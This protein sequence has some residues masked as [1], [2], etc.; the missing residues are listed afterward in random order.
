MVIVSLLYHTPPPPGKSPPLTPP[1]AGGY[2]FPKE[3]KVNTM[4]DIIAVGELLIDFTPES[5]P[6]AEQVLLSQNPGGAPGNV[7]AAAAK[8]GAN[9]ALISRVG[10][11]A[12]G[13]FLV[14]QVA[15]CGVCPDY[16]TREPSCHTTLAF[17]HLDRKGERSFSFLRSPGADVLLSRSHIPTQAIAATPIFHFGGVSL[18]HDPAR[19]ATL[20]A[21]NIAHNAG[22]LVSFDPNWRPSLWSDHDEAPLLL[23]RVLPDVDVIKVS[24]EELPLMTGTAD[25][26]E[27][28]R[29]LSQAGVTLVLVSR[30]ELGAYYR[31]GNLTGRLEGYPVQ[32]VDTTGAGDAFM[33]AVLYRLKGISRETLRALDENT[34]R[35]IVD[36]ANAA[37]ALATTRTGAIAVMPSLADIAALRGKEVE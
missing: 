35:D 18:T 10:A 7:M 22:A 25:L 29:R 4:H 1:L 26:E 16:I 5:A 32:T 21:L 2:N 28:A 9:T 27:G 14:E 8:L 34:L 31:L 30:G 19:D 37:G 15:K 20:F 24:E 11:D 3:R 6:G 36:F 23:R 12:F 13:D 17:V 33:G